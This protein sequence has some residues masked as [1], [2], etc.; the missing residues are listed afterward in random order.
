VS[1]AGVRETRRQGKLFPD[2][3]AWRSPAGID[4]PLELE[5][6]AGSDA[7]CQAAKG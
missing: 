2:G 3:V 6:N 5:Y 1:A 7:V 4:Y